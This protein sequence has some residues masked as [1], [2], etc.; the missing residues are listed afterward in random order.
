ME[1]QFIISTIVNLLINLTYTVLSLMIGMVALKFI[2]NSLLKNIDLESE[3]KGGNIA[4]AIF[5]STILLFVA[6]I[7]ALGLKG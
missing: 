3:I 6:L 5:A 2:D 1:V 4:A 7:V